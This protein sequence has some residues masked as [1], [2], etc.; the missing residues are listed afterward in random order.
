[1]QDFMLILIIFL[2]MSITY[3]MHLLFNIFLEVT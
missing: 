2:V 1:M 3:S